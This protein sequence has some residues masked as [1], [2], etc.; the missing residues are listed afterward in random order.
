MQQLLG[1]W[2]R[3]STHFTHYSIKIERNPDEVRTTVRKTNA[4]YDLVI[5][6]LHLY[7]DMKLVTF[8]IDT[9]KT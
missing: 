1:F 9:D 8:G 4:D 5:K 3:V 7:Y 2:Q 6:R